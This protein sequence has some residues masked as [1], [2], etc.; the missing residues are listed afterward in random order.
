MWPHLFDAGEQVANL[1]YWT[2][3]PLLLCGMY[4]LMGKFTRH[5]TF[6]LGILLLFISAPIMYRNFTSVLIQ[7]TWM[8]VLLLSCVY[9]L[10][11]TLRNKK[12]TTKEYI[13]LGCIFGVLPLIKPTG[14]LYLI[15]LV[16]FLQKPFKKNILSIIIGFILSVCI[17]GYPYILYQNY[18]LYGSPSGSAAFSRIHVA[19]LSPVQLITHTLRLPFALI[20]FPCYTPNCLASSD[21]KVQTLASYIG[22]TTIL[23]KETTESW[24][25]TFQYL[26]SDP[27]RNFGFGGIVWFILIM[28]SLVD[29][30][31]ILFK[32]QTVPLT[33]QVLLV[34]SGI[35]LL[36]LYV[37]RWEDASGVPYKHLVGAFA[38]A[39]VFSYRLF[40]FIRKKKYHLILLSLYILL[41]MSILPLISTTI[42]SIDASSIGD[43][44]EAIRTMRTRPNIYAYFLSTLPSPTTFLVA[45]PSAPEYP[46]FWFQGHQKNIV[47]LLSRLPE[48]SEEDNLNKIQ[49]LLSQQDIHYVIISGDTQLTNAIL[50]TNPLYTKT[51][52]EFESIPIDI[53][54]VK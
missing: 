39:C 50:N 3:F 40:D 17:S 9:I 51:S 8:G 25:G 5:K 47:H 37:V 23:E 13:L 2:A 41:F 27:D 1:L 29:A 6:K 12:T 10:I 52:M 16:F 45:E 32:K 22:A 38:I 28:L 7:E 26:S 19:S 53:I 11:D 49:Q 31:R 30:Y 43:D 36:Q 18:Q 35:I 44:Q 42:A 46:L 15:L 21:T 33:H 54:H 4:L 24:I 14:W 48:S 34:F 20:K